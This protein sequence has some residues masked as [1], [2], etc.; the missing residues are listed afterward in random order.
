MNSLP[1]L[2]GVF[3]AVLLISTITSTKVIT[4][5]S[6]TLDGGTLLFPLSYI[7]GDIITEVYG[8]HTTRKIIW[9]G[10]FALVLF[11]LLTY[12]IGILPSHAE[13]THQ[14][15][16]NAILGTTP[17]IILASIIAFLF[18]ELTNSYI[19]A[20]L[21]SE[22]QGK[23]LYFRMIFSSVIGNGIDTTLFI[24]IAFWG[25]FSGEVI[26]ALLFSNYLWK[27]GSEVLMSPLTARMIHFLKKR[28]ATDVYEHHLRFSLFR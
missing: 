24:C 15:S 28:D 27:L 4:F 13:W 17:R 19:M 26:L 20:R 9:T 16:Y 14:S 23:K 5:G 22:M 18:G 6:F 21:K 11:A 25:I 12:T 10:I 8:Y 7:L 1:I 2:S 3:I